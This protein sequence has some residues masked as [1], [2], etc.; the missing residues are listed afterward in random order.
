LEIQFTNSVFLSV[1][2]LWRRRG[3]TVG[4]VASYGK[5]VDKL[6]GLPVCASSAP[7]PLRLLRLLLLL[8]LFIMPPILFAF[9]RLSSA[10]NC[11]A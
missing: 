8:V 7:L 5:S 3:L 2:N 4:D 10:R 6:T 1:T 9:I 11:P